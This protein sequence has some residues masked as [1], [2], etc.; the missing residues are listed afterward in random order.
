MVKQ[1][2]VYYFYCGDNWGIKE[3]AGC[4]AVHGE[5]FLPSYVGIMMNHCKDGTWNN[6]YYMES[7]RFFF[8]GPIGYGIFGFAAVFVGPSLSHP[9]DGEPSRTVLTI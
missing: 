5:L 6:Q 9:R 8:H 7:K 3:T 4:F 2:F 1:Y